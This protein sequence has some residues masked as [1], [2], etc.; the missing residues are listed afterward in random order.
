MTTM[1]MTLTT[2]ELYTREGCHLCDDALEA[3][4]RVR[5]LA[6]FELQIID[7]DSDPLLAARYGLEVPVVLIEGKKVAKFRIDEALI[8]R[9]LQT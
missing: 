5:Q 2:V 3:L 4:E 1:T 6:P 7:V 9:R 8:L